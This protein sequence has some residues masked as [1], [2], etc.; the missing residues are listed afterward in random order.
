MSMPSAE[1]GPIF[2]C[3][4]FA[5]SAATSG[6]AARADGDDGRNRHAAFSGRSVRRAHQRVDGEV[7]IGVR[8]HDRVVLGAAERLHALALRGSGR[9]DVLRDRRGPDERHGLDVGMMQDGVH[10]FLVSVDDVEHAVRQAGFLEQLGEPDAGGRILLRRL[11]HERVPAGQRHREH[12]HRDHGREV[13]RRDARADADRLQA[14]VGV[15]AAADR[16]G[17][18]ALEQLRRA[19]RRTRRPRCRAGPIPSRRETPCRAL[20]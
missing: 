10:R 9:V 13:E 14:R 1:P 15:D 3:R 11:E 16:L 7:E 18:I 20:R 4:A 12:P 6:S 5:A 19:R 8:Q 2:S 17:V